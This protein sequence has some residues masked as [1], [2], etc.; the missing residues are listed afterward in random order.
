MNSVPWPVVIFDLDGTVADTIGLIIASY[1]HAVNSVLGHHPDPAVVR[2]WIGQ[3]LGDTFTRCWPS[4]AGELTTSYREFNQSHHDELVRPYSGVAELLS[5]LTAAG[6][7]TGIATSKG[8][9]AAERSVAVLG[10]PIAVTVSMEDTDRHKPDPQPV[11]LAVERL[12]GAGRR[13]VYV[14]DAVVDIQA[15]RAAGLDAI[16]VTWGAGEAGA[17][18]AAGPTAIASTVG[19]LRALLLG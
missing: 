9:P 14:G 5:E 7:V 6:I 1:D 3:T 19:E 13:A 16:A 4:Q 11:L 10:L 2:G 8:R 12:G 18:E 17:L 15:A